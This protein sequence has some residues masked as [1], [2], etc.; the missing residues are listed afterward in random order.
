MSTSTHHGHGKLVKDYVG[1]AARAHADDYDSWYAWVWEA[2][3][4]PHGPVHF[5]IGGYTHCGAMA[6]GALDPNLANG[7]AAATNV[8]RIVGA[9]KQRTVWIP[10][11]QPDFNV[12]VLERFGPSSLVVLRELDESDRFVQK[13]AESTL[14]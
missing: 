9:I 3:Y 6:I 12:R 10:K 11:L 1:A 7:T 13:S 5:M 2:S 4:A 14:I 8:A